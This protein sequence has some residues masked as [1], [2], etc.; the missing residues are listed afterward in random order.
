MGFGSDPLQQRFTV[1]QDSAPNSKGPP[2]TWINPAGG[3]N[4]N[5]RE[6]Y[7]WN[8]TAG[9]WELELSTGGDTP[10]REVDGSLWRDTSSGSFKAYDAGV[11]AWVEISKVF[12]G[13]TEPAN[14][15]A[16]DLWQDTS[17]N[18]VE[19]NEYT[20]STWEL[21]FGRGSDNPTYPVEGSLWRDT[22]AGQLKQYDGSSWGSVGVTDHANLNNVTSGQHHAKTSQASELSDVSADSSDSAHHSP[23]PT[24]GLA[25]NFGG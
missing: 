15:R 25:P 18:N 1:R 14:P 3:Q 21:W 24:E 6:T 16:G 4:G 12:R 10:T 2:W 13:D 5:N 19:L 7:L 17:G 8:D 23:T 11:S 20:G 22:S 9:Q